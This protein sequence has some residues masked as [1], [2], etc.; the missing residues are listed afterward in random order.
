MAGLASPRASPRPAFPLRLEAKQLLWVLLLASV[1][2]FVL[3]PII[4]LLINSFQPTQIRPTDPTSFSLE[5]WRTAFSEPGIRQAVINTV[6]IT[7]SEFVR[8][9]LALR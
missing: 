3:Y 9:R 2:F 6:T 5:G 8:N 7:F 4:L 1:A